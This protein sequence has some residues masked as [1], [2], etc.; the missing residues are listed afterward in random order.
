MMKPGASNDSYG[1]QYRRR[2]CCAHC[3]TTVVPQWRGVNRA[4]NDGVR[5]LT[6]KGLS[7]RRGDTAD[8]DFEGLRTGSIA[9]G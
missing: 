9:A 3:E 4:D 2:R 1:V 6:R 8:T 7:K 5:R